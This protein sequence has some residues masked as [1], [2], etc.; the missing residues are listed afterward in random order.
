MPLKKRRDRRSEILTIE[1]E[2]QLVEGMNFFE[3]DAPWAVDADFRRELWLLYRDALIAR[4]GPVE[5]LYGWFEFEANEEQRAR[6]R[7]DECP[8]P[9]FAERDGEATVSLPEDPALKALRAAQR[10]KVILLE[11][12]KHE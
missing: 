4:W 2:M 5:K 1:L 11:D 6:F 10:A 9:G 3:Q 12:A 8:S 7:F